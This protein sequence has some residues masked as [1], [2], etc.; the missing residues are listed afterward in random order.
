MNKVS[1]SQS[2]QITGS[3]GV[4][5]GP[6]Q[7]S[8]Q[9]G[10]EAAPAIERS[11][12]VKI[13]FLAANPDG[14]ERL[15][16]DREA[17]AIEEALRAGG[18][19]DRFELQQS[20]AVSSAE[21]Q[22]SLLRYA[23]DVVHFSG[24]GEESGAPV[25]EPSTVTRHLTP[26]AGSVEGKGDTSEVPLVEALAEL[27]SLAK[28]NIRCVLLNSCHSE[29]QARAL[30]EHIDCVIG[31][32]TSVNDAVAIQF[33][34][35]FYHALGCG[36]NLRRSFDL[37]CAQAKLAGASD[38]DAPRLFAPRTDPAAIVLARHDS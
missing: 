28:G 14:T 3:S 17:R 37:A 32:P 22:D 5:I 33:S 20:W 35:A 13:L 10:A 11:Q 8:L 29:A 34:W 16:L 1:N 38:R 9:T 2:F 30:A 24:H 12:P 15:R 25:L 23:P 18:L 7:Q 6:V 31:M 27:F 21:L 19:R 36:E 26:P 4:S